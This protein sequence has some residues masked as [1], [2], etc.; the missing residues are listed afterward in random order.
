[1]RS[2]VPMLAAVLFVADAVAGE[3]PPSPPSPAG[4]RP[5]VAAPDAPPTPASARKLI[6]ENKPADALKQVNR[7]LSMRG[8]SAEGL[9]RYEVLML[10]GEAHLRLKA[11][12]AAA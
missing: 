5:A 8:K 11:T 10:K 4:E 1:M 12:E 7:M 6:D 9:D 2:L 3:D